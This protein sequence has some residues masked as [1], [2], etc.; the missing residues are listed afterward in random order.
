M[1]GCVGPFSQKC[2]AYFFLCFGKL[3]NE[4][5]IYIYI[6]SDKKRSTQVFCLIW[7]SG[8]QPCFFLLKCLY[9]AP[10]Q[11]PVWLGRKFLQ[12]GCV[13][14]VV[15][16]RCDKIRWYPTGK[17]HD[18]WCIYVLHTQMISDHECVL[19]SFEFICLF[20]Y[21]VVYCS[22]VCIFHCNCCGCALLPSIAELHE[23][24]KW[25]YRC[26]LNWECASYSYWWM[27]M[28]RSKYLLNFIQWCHFKG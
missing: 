14:T 22:F 7:K 27:Q 8:I 6:S 9:R 5:Y 17:N 25:K 4:L 12:V 23:S 21:S 20:T 10:T 24:T 18:V 3:R 28:V 1:K 11:E 26:N 13:C 15:P 2:P 16:V 19:S